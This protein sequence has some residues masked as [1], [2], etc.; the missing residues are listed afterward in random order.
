M[1]VINALQAKAGEK[2]E[3]KR[4]NSLT[5]PVQ[6][7]PK[8]EKDE[9]W[10]NWNLD[11]LEWQGVKQLRR[12]AKKL[13]KNYKLAK[14]L[15]DRTD[16]II[17]EDPETEDVLN[18]LTEE[19]ES[20][21]ELKF[22]PIIPNVVNT[23]VTEFSKRSTKLS[24]KATDELS[25]NEALNKKREMVEEYLLREARSKIQNKLLQFGMDPES[26][27]FQE[28]MSDEKVRSLP[29]IQD[30]MDKQYISIPEEWATHQHNADSE[31]FKL[32]ELEET[33]FL[34]MLVTDREFWHFKMYE[35]DYDLELWNPVLTFYHKSPSAKYIS[36][37]NWVGKIDMMTIADVI[38]KY[39]W[40]MN[41]EQLEALEAQYPIKSAIYNVGGLQNDGSYYDG[42]KSHKWNTEMP[43]LAMRQF[44]SFFD[45]YGPNS[46]DI[47]DQILGESEDFLDYS[48][49][50]LLRVT[51]TYWKSQRKIGHLVKIDE[52]GKVFHDIVDEDYKISD[53]PQYDTRFIKNKEKRNL[54]FGEHI[55]WIWINEIWGG[56][57][58]GPSHF[59]LFGQAS[60]SGVDPIYL[61][62]N[63]NKVGRLK[64]Q[65]KGDDNI[66]G[67]KLPVE[68]CVF[69]D[70]NTRSTSLVDLMKPFQIAYNIVNNQIA[71]ILVDELGTIIL[72]DQNALPRHSMGEDW[73]KGN[74]AKAYV[75]MKNFQM[76][77]LDSTISNTENA[78]AFQHYQTLNL[79]Q[80][81]RLMSRVQLAQYFKQQCF[82]TI[83]ITPQRLGQAIDQETA[84]G[85]RTAVSTSYAQTEIYFTQHCDHL[86]PRIHKMRT[87]LAQ[88]YHSTN[89]SVRLSY[90]SSEDERIFFELEGTNLML[91]DINVFA[92]TKSNHRTLIEKL[93]QLAVTNNTTGAS[94][95]DLAGII[96]A[97]SLSE[98]TQALRASERKAQQMRQE[99]QQMQQQMQ[100]QA[101]EAEA[102]EK[103][104]ERD[105]KEMEAE[106]N[107][108]K[109]ILVAEIR[110]AGYGSLMDI[111]NNQQS[112]FADQMKEIRQGEEYEQTM[113]FEKEKENNR[114]A[115]NN[116]KTNLKREELA[117][118]REIK[119][120]ELQIARENKNQYDIK[121]QNQDKKKKK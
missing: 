82:E 110:A 5:Q 37:G 63:Q 46:N 92:T 120:K 68:G 75:A 114:M 89:P 121:A 58:I 3:N 74:L 111:D 93:K 71:D 73:G 40:V 51:T 22:Y 70:R 113:S 32:E 103:Q 105:H 83:G 44:T 30:F 6:F 4:I 116:E 67:C 47:V 11:W 24:F 85:V 87:D 9:E 117:T 69:N 50:N 27:E 95:Y 97:D 15:I 119:E 79:E 18:I 39:G 78:L 35:D 112:D 49:S 102:I 104:A 84:E 23:L 8:N 62:I 76:L 100:E 16:Y 31:R 48:D 88:Y 13:L 101:L 34:D 36:E 17:N 60:N 7:L 45:N 20:A 65:F 14:G 12:N 1:K 54:I 57:K 28:E 19:D 109:D 25:Y 80:T 91:R 107:R 56:V 98:V 77:P 99:D 41:Q 94:I 55:E 66:Y 96:K 33:A 59:S 115:N 10:A 108:R 21:L 2:T 26:P 38:D 42:T 118:K 64:F 90:L 106:K 72:F 61:G 81:N 52:A 86:M 43:S 29:E 53:K